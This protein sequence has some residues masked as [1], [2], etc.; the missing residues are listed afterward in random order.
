MGELQGF[1][2]SR[3]LSHL[4]TVVFFCYREMWSLEYEVD[5]L[6]AKFAESIG[7]FFFGSSQF[8]G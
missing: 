3:N 6:Q 7:K 1:E 2:I 8:R 4:S 5:E